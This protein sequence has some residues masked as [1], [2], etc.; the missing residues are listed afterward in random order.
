MSVD[1]ERITLGIESFHELLGAL[2]SLPLAFAI[3]YSQVHYIRSAI[4]YG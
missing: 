1:V 4:Y 3:L 2:C